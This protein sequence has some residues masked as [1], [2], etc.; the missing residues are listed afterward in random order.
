MRETRSIYTHECVMME[1]GSDVRA[2]T[3]LITRSMCACGSLR[4]VGAAPTA[5]FM[6]RWYHLNA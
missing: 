2:E 4:V 6:I 3:F 5:Q 1:I